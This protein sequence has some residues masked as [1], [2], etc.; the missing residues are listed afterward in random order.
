[1]NGLAISAILASIVYVLLYDWNYLKIF[2]LVV[3]G[4]FALSWTFV[5]KSAEKFNTPRRKIMMIT[6]SDPSGP[7][8]YTQIK[9]R[10]QK[11]LDYIERVQKSSGKKITVT[12]LVCK[13]VGNVVKEYPELSGKL[14]FGNF[15]PHET[16]DVSCLVALE[17]GKDLGQIC[18]RGIDQKT[19]SSIYD[20]TVDK[21]SSMR[22]KDG[23]YRKLHEKTNAPFKL[24]PTCVG[25][26]VAEISS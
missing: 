7:E 25:G 24:I 26:I 18:F 19:L 15:V 22:K 12:H 11:T 4:H 2:V 10:F 13:V 14:M 9:C 5:P 16:V 20:E 23:E 6:W 21:V 1:M 8:I 17:E 3:C